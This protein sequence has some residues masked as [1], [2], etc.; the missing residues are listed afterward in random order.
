MNLDWRQIHETLFAA[1]LPDGGH[2]EL[3]VDDHTGAWHLFSTMPQ[4]DGLTYM[5]E[6]LHGAIHLTTSLLAPEYRITSWTIHGRGQIQVLWDLDDPDPTP[7]RSRLGR[8]LRRA[9]PE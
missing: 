5:G 1:N 8:L 9:E 2:V 6:E 3:G 7:T 4:L